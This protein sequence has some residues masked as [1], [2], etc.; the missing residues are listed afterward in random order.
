MTDMS[1]AFKEA[2]DAEVK[3]F[4]FFKKK[5]RWTFEGLDANQN[6]VFPETFIKLRFRPSFPFAAVADENGGHLEHVASDIEFDVCG[7]F[8]DATE[9]Q[10]LLNWHAHA[11]DITIGCLRM[12]DGCGQPIEK[13]ELS[14]AK[15]TAIRLGDENDDYLAEWHL[16]YEKAEYHNLAK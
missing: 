4:G 1:L 13:W 11:E 15:A 14:N 5:F 7:L 8:C 9:R 3:Q 16:A 2:Y 12:Y 10:K 6:V